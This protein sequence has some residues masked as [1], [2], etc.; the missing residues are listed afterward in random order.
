MEPTWNPHRELAKVGGG[1]SGSDKVKSTGRDL[2]GDRIKRHSGNI[3]I[4][5]LTRCHDGLESRMRYSKYTIIH[6]YS[7]GKT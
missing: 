1:T 5:I 7:L 4:D 2:D 6:V 3:T